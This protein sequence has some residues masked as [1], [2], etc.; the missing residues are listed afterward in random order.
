MR[1]IIVGA[2]EVGKQIARVLCH[3]KNDV[4]VIDLNEMILEN[5]RD[6]LDIMT[7]TGNGATGRNLIRAGVEKASLL[8]AVTENSE[9]NILTCNLANHFDVPKKIARIRSNEYFDSAN[10]LTAKSFGV[11]HAI[12]PEYECATDIL[13][14]LLRPAI[15]ETVKFSHPNAQMVNFQIKPGSPMIG[16]T[17]ASFPKP[18]ILS[19]LR[20]CAILR[21]GQLIIPRGDSNFI[22]FDEIYVAGD[23]IVIDELLSWAEPSSS[24][25]T[26]VIIAGGTHLGGILASMLSTAD[27][28]VS[29]IEPNPIKAER[30]ADILGS[31]GLIIQGESTTISVLEEAG[32]R[33]CDAFIAANSDDETNILS[34]IL[35]KNHGAKNVIAVTS[36]QDYL[37]IISGMTMIDCCFSPIVAAVNLLIKHVGTENRQTVAVLKRTSAEVLEMTVE[38]DSPIANLKI[39]DIEF[40]AKMVFALIIRGEKL[41]SAIGDQQILPKDHVII[42]TESQSVP[43]AE[44]L[45][46]KKRF[47]S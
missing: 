37:R 40:P 17:L 21:Y 13:D 23:Q 18:E 8:L 46:V 19:H 44:K 34:C 6:N 12:I 30:V 16:A 14:T 15:K 26:K 24:I 10:G 42:M 36:N 32:I 20:V 39:K 3:R 22:A 1:A 28:R 35:A 7:I 47:I 43:I 45:F 38:V 27:I 33:H 11:D 29:V 41:V 2:G 4:V 31:S 9:A 25:T 5:L